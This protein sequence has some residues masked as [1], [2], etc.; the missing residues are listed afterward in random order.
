[1]KTVNTPTLLMIFLM[2]T[3][4]CLQA[5]DDVVEDIERTI[6]ALEGDYPKLD[7]PERNR[8]S[9]M[10][11]N[12][13]ACE[14]LLEDLKRAV[15][16]EMVVNLD[17]Q[18]YWHWVSEPWAVRFGN[19]ESA[20]L[21]G[22][23]MVAESTDDVAATGTDSDSGS[24]EGEFSGTNNQES[25][26]DEA[27]FLKTDG[28]HIYMLNGQ[29]LLIMGV[30]EFGNLT[31]ESNLTIEG[32]PTQMMIEGDRLVISSSI[33]Y[34]NLPE[35]SD[36][37]NLMSEEVTV[38]GDSVGD[39]KDDDT[40]DWEST[41]TYTKV[42]NLVKYTVVDITNR[43]SPVIEKEMYIEG[44]YHTARMV[45]G[46]VRSVTHLWTY[47]DEIR[48]W[49]N[50]PDDYWSEDDL[51]K[52]MNIWNESVDQTVSH[53][54]GVISELTL[55]D[56][57]PH[58]YEMRDGEIFTHPLTYE[59][60]T[61]FSASADSAGRGFTTIM[62]IRMLDDEASLEVDHITSSWAHVYSSKDTLVL[63]EPA[64]D[65]WWFWRNS[66]WEDATNIH[67]FDI[68]DSN[69]TTYVASGRVEGT[70]NDQFSISEHNGDIRVA[71]T[72][73]NW[74]MWWRLA[75]F[76]D[77]GDPVWSG[78]TNQISILTDDGEG[79]LDQIGYI[80]G[81]AEGETIW[82]ARFVGD[83]GY[84]VTFM[85]IDPLWVLDLSDPYEPV[86]LG[87]LHVPGVSTYIHPIDEDNLLT[88]GI[89]GGQDGLG[90]DWSTTQ[91]SLFDVSNT[92]SPTLADTIPL[93]PAYT[94][95]NCMDIMTCGW[96]WSYSEATYEHKAFN[97]WA[98]ESLLA[99]P[100]STH[101]YVYDQIE[102]EGRVYSYSGY[103]YVSMLKMI[104]VDTE[105][106][107]LSNHGDVEHSGFY[108]EEGLSS[109]WSGS[110]SIRRSI[111]MGDYVYSFSGGG[112]TVHR[113]A[114]LQLVVEL[115]LPG[116]E[117]VDH[118]YA[119]EEVEVGTSGSSSEEVETNPC[120]EP[121]SENC[122]D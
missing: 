108:N 75:E 77:N 41:Y 60:C 120:N 10:L 38:E 14:T 27:D 31:L 21:D 42:Q 69:H 65:M 103:Q 35:D 26:V 17:Q 115:E 72:S 23:P 106:G 90:L 37:R 102:V 119:L 82:S 104:E 3:A 20:T 43:S 7:L 109:W 101:R 84:L 16:D 87:E 19:P 62:T 64:N 100:L 53:N 118:Y 121:D 81:I 12:Y 58:I 83:R 54:E 79:Y 28:F 55:D 113:T 114:D 96:S 30:P 49:V 57:V 36:L 34:W 46:T 71:S 39:D 85:N 59:K 88:I 66:D 80:G 111:F 22:E 45:D 25:G 63:A 24:R 1:M 11:Q 86:I 70:V 33:Y 2:A 98:P 94:D 97:Y 116:N 6:D 92:S 99:V 76:D 78:P 112:A 56:F 8:S 50:L 4:G 18:S 110:T 48:T 15:Y 67:S 9:P 107:T 89:A 117:P 40:G 51:D 93:T 68:S 95:E 44:N 61:E 47:F 52:R 73:D 32:N 91:V 5:V 122:E 13:D 29:L 74:G 105:N